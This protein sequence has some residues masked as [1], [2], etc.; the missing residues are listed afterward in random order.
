MRITTMMSYNNAVNSLN[1][2]SNLIRKYESQLFTGKKVTKS[3]DDP[4]SMTSILNNRRELGNLEQYEKN[5]ST[6]RS[7]IQ[8]TEGTLM[9]LQDIFSRCRDLVTQG[10]NG[11][12]D[13]Q[14]RDAI[15]QEITE[16]RKQ[17]GLLANTKFGEYYI[18]GGVDTKMPP[19]NTETMKWQANPNANK[20]LNIEVSQNTYIDI[21]MNG[22]AIFNG[23]GVANN[24][25]DLLDNITN[26]LLAG[27]TDSLGENRIQELDDALNQ[28]TNSISKIG[29]TVNRLD[30][31]ESKNKDFELNAQDDLSNKEDADIEEVYIA[32]TTA[33]TVYNAGI[34]VTAKILQTSLIDFL[35]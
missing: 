32:L 27:D 8:T 33:R 30:I 35:K 10:S 13:Q 1:N 11:T 15:A 5:I 12:Y 22:E 18:F 17:V 24:L 3:S 23:G 7:A 34:S 29:S 31:I 9:Q 6:V 14:S 19:Y 21:N 26:D 20:P 4:I 28:I 16:L 2:T 25:F